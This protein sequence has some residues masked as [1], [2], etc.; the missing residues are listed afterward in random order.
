MVKFSGCESLCKC[1]SENSLTR[2]IEG[3]GLKVEGKEGKPAR[4][5]R[6]AT[7]E[8]GLAP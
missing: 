3:Q 1:E 5:R 6:F 4:V 8:K 7:P 2:W